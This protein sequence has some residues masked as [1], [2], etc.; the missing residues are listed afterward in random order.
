MKFK[1]GDKVRIK[2]LDWYNTFKDEDGVVDCGLWCFDKK[3]SRFCGKIVTICESDDMFDWYRI[4]EENDS[5]IR[6]NNNMIECLVERNGKTYP[7]KV[8]DKVVYEDDNDIVVISEII[9]DDTVGDIFYNVKKIDEDDCF[10]CPPEL[11]KPYK[12]TNMNKKLAI[13]GHSTRGKE[14]IELLEMLGGN[15]FN[16]CM[17]IA[18][19]NRVYYIGN[20]NAITWDYIG[21]E[22]IDKYEIFTLEEFLEKYPFKVGDKVFLYDNITEGCVTGMKWEE[23]TVKYCVYTSAESWCDVKELLKWNALDLV[24]RHYGEQCEEMLKDITLKHLYE[25]GMENIK[26][27]KV[28][29]MDIEDASFILNY[30]ILPNKVNDELEYKIPDGYEITEVSKDTVF[31]KPIKPQYPKTYKECCDVLLIPPYYNLRYHTYEHCY[32]EYATSNTLLSLQDKLNTL[33]KLL[34]CRDAYWT[35]L[36]EEMGLG[37]PWEP[38]LENEE[39]YCIQ[40]YNK[41]IIKSKT[42]TAFNKILIFPTEEMRDAFFEDFKD[43]IEQC[44]KLL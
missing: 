4:R 38:D 29:R 41:Q 24:E 17:K 32:N 10:L 5:H 33:G 21:P 3:M 23:N 14:V 26:K 22:E 34:I 13:K 43:L 19:S 39:L 40:N 30:M 1:V 8:G 9:W 27:E 42:N 15:T 36:G 16:S 37:K 18:Y 44:K 31:I 20:N 35:I 11:L 12:E 6:Y 2:S 7:Y 25:L 28:R